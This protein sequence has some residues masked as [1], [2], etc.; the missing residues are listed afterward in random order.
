V[1]AEEVGQTEQP[2]ELVELNRYRQTLLSRIG[3]LEPIE[4]GLLEAHGCVLAQDVVADTPIPP[5]A[6]SAMDGFAVRAADTYPGAE[7]DLV[8]EIAAGAEPTTPLGAGEAIRIMTGAPLPPGADAIV[9]VEAAEEDGTRVRLNESGRRGRH[10]RPAGQDVGE[11]EV[12]LRASQRLGAA[13][14]GMLAAV[15]MTRVQVH[16]RPRVV[17]LSTGDELQEPGEALR[18]GAIRDA[19]SYALTALA[20]ESGAT[21]F[22][23]PIVPDDRRQLQEAFE[24]ALTQADLL[25]TTGGVSAGRYDYVKQVLA[26]L[27][28]V[29]FTKVG[30]QPGMPQ[31]FGFL[32]TVPC[33]GLPGN[34]V[35]AYVSFEVFVRPALRRMQ[36]RSDVNRPRV[37]AMLEDE[38]ESPPGKVS[39]LRVKLRRAEGQWHASLTGNQSSGILRSVVEADGLAE[40]PAG[41]TNLFP[42]ERVVV[43]LLV[44]TV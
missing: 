43:H 17:I 15:G 44:D 34:P 8:G 9:P 28:D 40:V 4:L 31:A 27:G 37:T 21:A 42:G 2:V 41:R 26:Q 14:I 5:F 30:M 38:V 16:P 13:D 6:N 39:F 36:G 33:F 29:R 19:N 22:R 3:P 12:V 32:G 24:G 11:G 25:V 20:S 23:M 18:P 35:S 1:S 10:I 7:L